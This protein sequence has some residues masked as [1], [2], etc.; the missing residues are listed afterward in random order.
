MKSGPVEADKISTPLRVPAKVLPVADA[1]TSSPVRLARRQPKAEIAP[2]ESA[3][4]AVAEAAESYGSE[5]PSPSDL[6]AT[7]PRRGDTCL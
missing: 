7:E 2:I 1:E 3:D 4:E 5:A 6:S